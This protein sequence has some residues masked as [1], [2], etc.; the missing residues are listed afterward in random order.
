MALDNENLIESA[1]KADVNHY[2]HP[3]SSI[4]AIQLNGPKMVEGAS[5]TSLSN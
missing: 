1:I 5:T 3:A 2:I 4:E